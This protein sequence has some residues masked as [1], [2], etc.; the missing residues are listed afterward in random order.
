MGRAA[1]KVDFGRASGFGERD[2]YR[3]RDSLGLFHQITSLEGVKA[4][5]SPMIEPRRERSL[6]MKMRG[7][8]ILFHDN[9]RGPWASVKA[10]EDQGGS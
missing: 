10:L 1:P 6:A 3:G 8:R 7:S 5:R 2:E 9:V 4:S